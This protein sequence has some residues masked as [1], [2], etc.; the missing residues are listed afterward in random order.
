[1]NSRDI[2][3]AVFLCRMFSRVPRSPNSLVSSGWPRRKMRPQIAQPSPTTLN[4]LCSYAGNSSKYLST[5]K[6]TKDTKR[7]GQFFYFILP[8]WSACSSWW[9]QDGPHAAGTFPITTIFY[10]PSLIC[11]E[12][13]QLISL[14]FYREFW[15]D[16]HSVEFFNHWGCQCLREVP[17]FN[18]D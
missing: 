15:K 12:I 1:M 14:E 10:S 8:W 4:L 7:E 3:P 13:F 5:T 2:W 17:R 16:L 11:A 18:V 9:D 6:G